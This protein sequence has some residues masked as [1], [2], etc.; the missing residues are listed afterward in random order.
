[1][2]APVRYFDTALGDRALQAS[3]LFQLTADVGNALVAA[4]TTRA[5]ALALVNHVNVIATAAASTG[6]VLPAMNPNDEYTIFNNGAN[7]IKVYAPG[8]ATIDGTAGATGVTLTNAKRA[9][10]FCTAAG[11]IISAQLG[12]ASA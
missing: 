4:G 1:M 8:S 6:V 10:F 3:D 9:Q 2:N 7:P 5:D 12:V 11:V